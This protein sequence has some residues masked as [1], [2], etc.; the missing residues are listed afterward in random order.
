MKRTAGVAL[1]AL[2]LLVAGCSKGTPKAVTPVTSH[3]FGD[4]PVVTDMRDAKIKEFMIINDG[5]ADLKLRDVQVK[6]L[7]GC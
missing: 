2:A 5:T 7:E 3:D 6:V 1:L 4:V